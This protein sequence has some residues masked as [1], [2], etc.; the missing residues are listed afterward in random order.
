MDGQPVVRI[1][2]K[3]TRM[4]SK[5]LPKGVNISDYVNNAVKEQ[6]LRD[7]FNKMETHWFGPEDGNE[8]ESKPKLPPSLEQMQAVARALSKMPN[9]SR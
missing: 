4:M 5:M 6:L 3:N 8:A 7:H 9:I 2:V 1:S